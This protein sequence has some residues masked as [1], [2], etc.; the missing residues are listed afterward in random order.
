MGDLETGFDVVG[1]EVAI[2]EV[3][4]VFPDVDPVDQGGAF[5]HG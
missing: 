3:V 1:A 5:H 2:L 4:G